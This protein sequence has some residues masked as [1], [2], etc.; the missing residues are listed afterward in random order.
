MDYFFMSSADEAASANPILVMVDESTGDRYARAVGQKGPGVFG[1]M[2]WLI[3][4]MVDELR[5]WGH[6]GG[7][8]GHIIL[9]SD[10]EPAIVALRTAV[11]R[12]LGG[13]VVPEDIPRGESQSNGTVEEAGKTVR[14]YALVLKEQL[15][16]E[17]GVRLAPDSNLTPWMIRWAAMVYSRYA[18]GRDGLTQYELRKGCLLYTSDAADE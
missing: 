11:G 12:Y 1:S 16:A 9:K 3:K 8:T 7:E 14:E 5:S 10:G 2:D 13:R 6:T 15:E 4:D 18:I 17:T